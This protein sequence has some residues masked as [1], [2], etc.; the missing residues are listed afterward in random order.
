MGRP[1]K[2][3]T[4]TDPV[5]LK[6]LNDNEVGY[7]A[8]LMLP[9]LL[10]A[11]GGTLTG[12]LTLG[13]TGTV[14]GTFTDTTRQNPVGT[15]PVG[16]SVNSTVYT[17]RQILTAVSDPG[18]EK[19][20]EYNAANYGLKQLGMVAGNALFDAALDHFDYYLQPTAPALPGT[21]TSVGTITDTLV[22]GTVVTANLW[23]KTASE[24]SEP[25]GR[26]RPIKLNGTN[27]KE[28][29][30]A[31]INAQEPAFQNAI[32]AGIGQYRLAE[33]APVETGTWVQQGT[34]LSD[35]IHQVANQ[36]YAGS[37]TGTFTGVYSRG[38]VGSYTNTY[39][40]AYSG[41]YTRDY[42]QAYSGT[43]TSSYSG[44]YTRGY[45]LT[46]TNTYALGYTRA[47]NLSYSMTYGKAYSGSY[48]G[49]YTLYYGGFANSSYSGDYAG[50]Y[51]GFYTGYYTRAY[52]LTYTNT[53]N[54]GY[55]RTYNFDYSG[56][57]D[58][59]YA[60]F[61]TRAYAQGYTGSYTRAYNQAY[62]GTYTNAYTG[63]YSRSFSGSYTGLTVLAAT[64]TVTNSPRKLWK[65]IA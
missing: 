24:F 50:S 13:G 39:N 56:S 10:P 62:S 8:G 18:H 33:T 38:Y 16:T 55:T 14:I 41:T 11:T 35:T 64:Q 22:D 36:S 54:L 59:G 40:L 27:L 20:L 26:Y 31:E 58:Q 42:N 45:N 12:E 63:A 57:Y 29:S 19:P 4:T 21:W 30:D 9:N 44:S 49:S 60:G 34:G 3:D 43:Y 25:A 51:T 48:T 61:Y 28:L 5:S 46:Y 47:Y 52:N 7:I 23:K 32:V 17:M 37:Y 1:L 15:H 6:E 65:R 53:Y 2:V